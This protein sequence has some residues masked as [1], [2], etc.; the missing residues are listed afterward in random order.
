MSGNKFCVVVSDT[1]LTSE[2]SEKHCTRHQPPEINSISSV[3]LAIIRI[4][5]PS[6]VTVLNYSVP[7]RKLV[8][9]DCT[10]IEFIITVTF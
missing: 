7:I 10:I 2:K 9:H 5:S 8:P 4:L 3:N 1:I 6:P